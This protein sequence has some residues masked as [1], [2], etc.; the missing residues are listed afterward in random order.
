MIR[1]FF[2]PSKQSLK[3]RINVAI[4][5]L[6]SQK[7]KLEH[8]MAKLQ[9]RDR[10]IFERC[11]GAYLSKDYARSKMYANECSEV[12]SI[13]K[14]LLSIQL[15]LERVILRLETIHEFS[16]L[17]IQLAPVLGLVKEMRKQIANIV[18][19]VA[20]GLDEVGRLLIT[21]VSEMKVINGHKLEEVEL[22]DE[23]RRIIE[24][25]AFIAEQKIR[26]SFPELPVEEVEKSR[27]PITEAEGILTKDTP[28]PIGGTPSAS[29]PTISF[30]ELKVKLLE[31]IQSSK[32]ALKVSVCARELQASP[33][34]VIRAL[35]S[36]EEE[37]KI[38]LRR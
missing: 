1:R 9:R 20:N 5:K 18:P 19:D 33:E 21:T 11:V 28:T 15:A 25:A 13:A 36:L 3:E 24:E 26:E 12:R 23:A 10:E 16:D 30:D 29:P 6:E 22:N 7:E 14:L 27:T 2:A 38:I 8:I 35:K 17:M 34:D 4:Y 31:Y 32:G 37:G